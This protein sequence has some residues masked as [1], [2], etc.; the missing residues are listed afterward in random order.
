M[1]RIP[2]PLPFPIAA[3]ILMLA[4]LVPSAA[5]GPDG[6]LVGGAVYREEMRRFLARSEEIV[7]EEG[8]AADP[9]IAEH[10]LCARRLLRRAD[11]ALAAGREREAVSDLEGACAR[12][13]GAVCATV[14]KPSPDR[15][16]RRIEAVLALRGESRNLAARCPAPGV[17]TL[18]ALADRRLGVGRRL[19]ARGDLDSATAEIA[20]AHELYRRIS[21][22]CARS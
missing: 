2:R 18:M 9:L 11:D 21:E 1:K 5:A 16:E 8:R 20:V 7:A 15:L 6:P 22:L 17:E 13:R 19:A 4:A 10:L 14:G 12:V 3:V